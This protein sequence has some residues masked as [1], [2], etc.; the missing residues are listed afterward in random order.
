MSVHH[1]RASA[2]DAWLSE[3]IRAQPCCYC[4]QELPYPFIAWWGFGETVALHVGCTVELCIRLLR[5]VHQ[6][7][8]ETHQDVTTDAVVALRTRLRRE[9]GLR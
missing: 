2:D 1:Y 7:E 9:E 3:N 8:C 4:G 6:V 5:D